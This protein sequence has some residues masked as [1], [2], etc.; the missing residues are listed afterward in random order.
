M[1]VAGS[2]AWNRVEQDLAPLAAAATAAA[3][4]ALVDA[5]SNA[6]SQGQRTALMQCADDI[7]NVAAK[8]GAGA[9]APM[10]SRNSVPVLLFLTVSPARLQQH[11]L[12]P[13]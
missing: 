11:D 8:H 12:W 1:S 2:A 13:S 9:L 4:A 3:E 10:A 5:S 7:E 6:L